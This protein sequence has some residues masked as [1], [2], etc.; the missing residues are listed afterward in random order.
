[1]EETNLKQKLLQSIGNVY[2]R[3]KKCQLKEEFFNEIDSEL[4]LL[5]GYFRV[6]RP[7]AF[8]VAVVMAMNYKGDSVDFNDLIQ[9]FRCN[10]M[11]ILNYSDDFTALY[12]KGIFKKEK[13]MHRKQLAFANDQFTVSSEVT[14]AV[15]QNKPMPD[16]AD[17]KMEDVT[18]V[19]GQLFSFSEQRLSGNMSALNCF[20]NHSCCFK[21]TCISRSS[22]K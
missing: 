15:L 21:T 6:T 12:N 11:T 14:D 18:E 2:E 16:V 10:P 4:E 17:R 9:Y 3:A 7:Q 19:L 1:M 20:L 8:F 13:S 5:S 22:G